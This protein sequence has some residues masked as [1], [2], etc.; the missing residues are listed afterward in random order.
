MLD[1]PFE[2]K[3]EIIFVQVRPQHDTTHVFT[4]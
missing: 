3:L 1:A 2:E 4:K